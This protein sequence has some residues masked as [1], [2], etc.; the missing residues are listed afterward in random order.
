MMSFVA[1]IPTKH[2]VPQG[3]WEWV[4]FAGCCAT[5]AIIWLFVRN[6]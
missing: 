1:G 6:R 3:F 5:I 4:L 2:A